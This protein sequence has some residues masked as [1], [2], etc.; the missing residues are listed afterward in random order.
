[1]QTEL[2]DS[3]D[4]LL[5]DLDVPREVRLLNEQLSAAKTCPPTNF[6]K[7]YRLQALWM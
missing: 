3:I 5:A 6:G 2:L 4:K 7:R 1:M